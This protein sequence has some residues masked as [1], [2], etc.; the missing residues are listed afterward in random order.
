MQLLPSWRNLKI[1]VIWS[2]NLLRDSP[3]HTPGDWRC[4]MNSIRNWRLRYIPVFVI[5]FW[6]VSPLS[7]HTAAG[8]AVILRDAE[9]A[10]GFGVWVARGTP[11]LGAVVCPELRRLQAPS[12]FQLA[13][14]IP[15]P[16]PHV[17]LCELTWPLSF[18]TS[19]QILSILLAL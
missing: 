8:G 2:H 12:L 11:F 14:N 18:Y 1:H 16:L 17:S 4:N 6:F 19:L 5:G 7:I 9:A 10:L 3:D 13:F 15:H